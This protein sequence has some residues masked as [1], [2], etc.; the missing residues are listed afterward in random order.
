MKWKNIDLGTISNK[1]KHFFRKY[2]ANRHK[3]TTITPSMHAQP[4]SNDDNRFDLR[5]FVY[6]TSWEF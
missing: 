6:N 1:V 5:Q 2:A 3:M 4:Y